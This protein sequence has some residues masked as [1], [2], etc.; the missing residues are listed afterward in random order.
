MDVAW[1]VP[2]AKGKMAGVRFSGTPATVAPWWSPPRVCHED[3]I[4]V[5][6]DRRAM[7]AERLM[8]TQESADLIEL[9]RSIADKEL[10]PLVGE[11]ER[12]HAFHREVFTV[13][14]RAG[15]LSLP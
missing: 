9:T 13:L 4:P 1:R 10:R 7:P 3:L 2:G 5:T 6:R 14:G 12:A 11:A 15:L 8:P